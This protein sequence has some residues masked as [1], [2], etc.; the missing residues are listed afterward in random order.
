MSVLAAPGVMI[1]PQRCEVFE[2]LYIKCKIKAD[3]IATAIQNGYVP[4]FK[5]EETNHPYE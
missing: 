5:F 3:N 1:L 4:R 2:K